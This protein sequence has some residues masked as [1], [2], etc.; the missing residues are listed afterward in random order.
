MGTFNL[1]S[2][3]YAVGGLVGRDV[4]TGF[5]TTGISDS[6]NRIAEVLLK[7]NSLFDSIKKYF[8]T[9]PNQTNRQG[10][11]KNQSTGITNN[12]DIKVM[13]DKSGG[14]TSSNDSRSS[15]SDQEDKNSAFKTSELL[16]AEILKVM[17]KESRPGGLLK[18]SNKRG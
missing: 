15:S 8:D 7:L 10:D 14:Q 2:K 18:E 9:K 1:P 4:Y 13:I 11:N 5:S 6:E 16:K 12:I 3:G 17:L